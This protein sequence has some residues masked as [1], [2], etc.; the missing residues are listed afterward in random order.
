MRN[1][2]NV[3]R[4]KREFDSHLRMLAAEGVAV[5]RF[6]LS[7]KNQE[8]EISFVIEKSSIKF[9]VIPKQIKIAQDKKL[10][11]NMAT[12]FKGFEN[13]PIELLN[14]EMTEKNFAK[15]AVDK[16]MRLIKAKSDKWLREKAKKFF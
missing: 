10:M 11:K 9:K 4:F 3:N 2:G 1:S 5:I 6:E 8:A 13:V 12:V 15:E 7:R 14:Q 16:A